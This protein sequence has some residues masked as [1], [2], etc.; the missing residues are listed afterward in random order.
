MGGMRRYFALIL[1][2][3]VV[4]PN[5]AGCTEKAAS[6][7]SPSSEEWDTLNRW[8]KDIYGIPPVSNVDQ[9][10]SASLRVS[11]FWKDG[12]QGIMQKLEQEGIPGG[13]TAPFCYLLNYYILYD[14]QLRNSSTPLEFLAADYSLT[15]TIRDLDET[16]QLL[17]EMKASGEPLTIFPT[18]EDANYRFLE[19][20]KEYVN[21][22]EEAVNKGK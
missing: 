5:L 13:R 18:E 10:E 9:L 3:L 20:D 19:L 6:P 1:L 21:K 8:L 14:I 16:G 7:S 4:I 12:V 17:L 2:I 15:E 11:L 22:L